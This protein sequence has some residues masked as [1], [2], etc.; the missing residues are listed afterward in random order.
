[1]SE[2]EKDNGEKHIDA[3]KWIETCCAIM[4]VFITGFYTYFAAGQLHKMKRST[5]ATEKAANSAQSAADTAHSELVMVNRPWLAID[6]PITVLDSLIVDKDGLH[7]HVGFLI[8]NFGRGPAFH[9]GVNE[10]IRNTADDV[11]TDGTVDF[12]SFKRSADIECK[13]ADAKTHP[14]VPGESGSGP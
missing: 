13:M 5:E 8:K 12:T 2:P 3:P 4:L 14:I 7:A 9:V 6:G 11:K 10:E 1:M